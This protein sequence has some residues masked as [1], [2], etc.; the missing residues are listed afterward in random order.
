MADAWAKLEEGSVRKFCF[1][2]LNLLNRSEIARRNTPRDTKTSLGNFFKEVE[3]HVNSHGG[4]TWNLTDEEGLFGFYDDELTKMAAR[5]VTSAVD[6]I[7]NLER[8]NTTKSWVKQ[9]IHVRIS[10][11]LGDAVYCK[12]TNLISGDNVRFVARLN[13]NRTAPDTVSISGSVFQELS[14]KDGMQQRF[15]NIGTVGV[16]QVFVATS[17]PVAK[18]KPPRPKARSQASTR[19]I[20]RHSKWKNLVVFLVSVFGGGYILAALINWLKPDLN[21]ALNLYGP[22]LG[23]GVILVTLISVTV[24]VARKGWFKANRSTSI[25]RTNVLSRYMANLPTSTG[26]ADVPLVYKVPTRGDNRVGIPDQGKE[27]V[28]DQS[29]EPQQET[30]LNV[31]QLE[32][33]A[34]VEPSLEVRRPYRLPADLADFIGRE[35]VMSEMLD[36]L[37]PKKIKDNTVIINGIGGVGKSTLAVHVAHHL[38]DDYPDGQII[39][40]L[41]GTSDRPITPAEAMAH[42]IQSLNGKTRLPDHPNDVAQLYYGLLENRRVLLI[43]DN[44]SGTSQVRPLQLSPPCALIVTSRQTLSLPGARSIRVRDLS[45]K[46]ARLLLKLTA[47]FS[48]ERLTPLN[49]IA[50]M[51]SYQPLALR[52][53]GALLA[54]NADLTED[55]CAQAMVYYNQ[56]LS[57]ENVESVGLEAALRMSVTKLDQENP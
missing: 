35:Q 14:T 37:M 39:V 22:T 43:L 21:Y 29:S 18:S 55:K 42:V 38:A 27:S 41:C 28:S 8:F 20:K 34:T 33:N 23:V 31:G 12:E 16:Q 26:S 1:M 19:P 6:V 7:D 47:S 36:L 15:R 17:K 57:W 13:K 44:A 45:V 2:H 50:R 53:I 30:D 48:R 11:H 49:D 9:Q 54:T 32:D 10:V 5:A 40:D 25:R 24:V 56:S 46:E 51:C 52:V 3:R 4:R